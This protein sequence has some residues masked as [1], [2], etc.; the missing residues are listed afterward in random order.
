MATFS[1]TSLKAAAR[2]IE[3]DAR[4]RQARVERA[5][6]K[7]ANKTAPIVRNEL[8]PKAFGELADSIHVSSGKRGNADIIADAPH[9]EAVEAGSR[10]HMPPLAPIVKWVRLRGLQGITAKGSVKQ[11]IRTPSLK[12]EQERN[13]ARVRTQIGHL[14]HSEVG[15]KNASAAKWVRNAKLGAVDAATIAVAQAIRMKIAKNGTKPFRFMQAATTPAMVFLD[16]F[17]KDA[18]EDP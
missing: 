2:Q 18:L 13:T 4:A 8:V 10:P 1:F 17:V 6:L 5:V 14:I 3:K 11:N 15:G 9:A 12:S 7:A 16:T